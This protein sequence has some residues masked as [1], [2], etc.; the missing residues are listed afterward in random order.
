MCSYTKN[1]SSN[2]KELDI[3]KERQMLSIFNLKQKFYF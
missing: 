3:S 2:T 1:H